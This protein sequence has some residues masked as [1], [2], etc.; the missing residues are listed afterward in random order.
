MQTFIG[1]IHKKTNHFCGIILYNEKP[2]LTQSEMDMEISK[3][4]KSVL[5]SLLAVV[6]QTT[7]QP[8][9]T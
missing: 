3:V 5:Y 1:P 4:W 8:I 9:Y 7:K 6:V 2:N